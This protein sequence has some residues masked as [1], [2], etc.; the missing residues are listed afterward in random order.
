M[1]W[2]IPVAILIAGVLA[3]PTSLLLTRWL[4]LRAAVV[5]MNI[6]SILVSVPVIFVAFIVFG[7]SVMSLLK[8]GNQSLLGVVF[9]LA[10][11]LLFSIGTLICVVKSIRLALRDRRSAIWVAYIPIAPPA[12]FYLVGALSSLWRVAVAPF[13]AGL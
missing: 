7:F 11:M 4:G 13:F 8:G 12:M 10:A 1:D 6:V 2:W 9:G 5:A 3:P